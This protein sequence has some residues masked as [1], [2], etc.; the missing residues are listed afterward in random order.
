MPKMV[1]PAL[2]HPRARQRLVRGVTLVEVLVVLVVVALLGGAVVLGSGS[3]SASRLRGA[4]AAI[5][6]LSRTAGTRA[7]STGYPVRIVFDLNT[8]KLYLEQ[9][10]SG[11]VVRTPEPEGVGQGG[12]SNYQAA[13]KSQADAVVEDFLEGTGPKRARFSRVK[14]LELNGEDIGEG[15]DLGRGIEFRQVE[16]EHDEQAL[17]EG[18]AYLYFWPG[19]ETEWASVQIRPSGTRDGLTVLIS[20]LTGRARIL[21]GFVELPKRG[22]DGE[23]S[24]LEE[25]T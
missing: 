8:H 20:P 9:S 24:E 21:R 19:G 25:E 23:I 4:A 10:S 18:R 11:S 2:S 22:E 3:V 14:G 1:N 15:C 7:S 17:T 13:A 16:V 6:A 5:V 12:A